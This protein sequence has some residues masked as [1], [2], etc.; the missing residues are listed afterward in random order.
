MVLFFQLNFCCICVWLVLHSTNCMHLEICANIIR[1]VIYCRIAGFQCSGGNDTTLHPD[2]T[3]CYY[4]YQCIGLKSYRMPC[5]SG[6]QFNAA[7]SRCDYPAN[8]SC[9]YGG[10]PATVIPPIGINQIV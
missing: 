1:H 6:L 3:N 9:V 10:S 5:P 7:T 8:A 2:T 4:F